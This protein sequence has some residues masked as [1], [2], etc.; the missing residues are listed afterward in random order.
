MS[1]PKAPTPDPELLAALRASLSQR[2]EGASMSEQEDGPLAAGAIAHQR[3]H[4]LSEQE[5]LT[6][7]RQVTFHRPDCAS[8]VE[9][10]FA[11]CCQ[12]DWP[13]RTHAT[14]VALRAHVEKLEKDLRERDEEIE[15]R[16][17]VAQEQ[18]A[19][20]ATLELE[21][22]K[23]QG[24]FEQRLHES[25]KEVMHELQRL[26]AGLGSKANES[27]EGFIVRN[28]VDAALSIIAALEA[29]VASLREKNEQQPCYHTGKIEYSEDNYYCAQCNRGMGVAYYEL[30]RENKRLREKN[31]ELNRR[32]TRAE[33]AV[34][35]TIEQMQ[36]AGGSLGRALA[37]V[38]YRL[39]IRDRDEARAEVERLTKESEGGDLM[40]RLMKAQ[41]AEYRLEEAVLEAFGGLD[42][43]WFHDWY[44]DTYD[45]SVELLDAEPGREPTP[46]Q[47]AALLAI[48]VR[49]IW[50][51][52]RDGTG[53]TW[54]C[55]KGTHGAAS[56]RE[57]R[58]DNAAL[59]NLARDRE[60]ALLEAL[61][62]ANESIQVTRAALSPEPKP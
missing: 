50:I 58:Q 35:K 9:M 14:I 16:E 31:S 40:D 56:P 13:D 44:F 48:G 45:S 23:Q 10:P 60:K 4:E 34:S 41:V 52:Y 8:A 29:E 36:R 53:Q 37:N 30:A 18:T 11:S 32:A 24:Y 6:A 46:E 27:P 57:S 26:R 3:A 1:E 38:G 61:D 12:T 62:A 54:N 17:E 39:A 21:L 42:A 47:L 7:E 51:S 25:T 20:I 55:E 5:S 15:G 33:G 22:Q 43:V 49:R 28:P 59:L 19:K 2:S